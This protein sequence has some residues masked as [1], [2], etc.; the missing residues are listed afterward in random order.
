MWVGQR[1][2]S[3]AGRARKISLQILCGAG[4][5]WGGPMRG[6]SAHIATP[7]KD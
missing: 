4:Q 5:V 3:C 1:A 6:G 7:K 2:N